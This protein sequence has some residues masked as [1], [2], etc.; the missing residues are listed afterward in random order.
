VAI[1]ATL[2]H[3]WMRFAHY[4]GQIQ[5]AILLFLIYVLVIGPLSVVLRVLGRQDLLEMRRSKSAS[6][7]HSKTQVPTDA[8]R[9]ERQF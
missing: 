2:K 8:A 1:F 7:A 3:G 6:F 5:T 9:C 4:L